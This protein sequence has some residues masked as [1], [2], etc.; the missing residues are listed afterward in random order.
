MR[1]LSNTHSPLLPDFHCTRDFLN[2][3]IAHQT[4]ECRPLFLDSPHSSS[5]FIPAVVCVLS[6]AF[7]FSCLHF[8]APTELQ[9]RSSTKTQGRDS[10][11]QPPVTT[12]PL[13]I[14]LPD[15]PTL[16]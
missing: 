14:E 11:P 5:L 16:R 2:E 3:I 8:P 9:G 6:I 4:A 12:G 10:N 13:P 15:N 1:V 7:F